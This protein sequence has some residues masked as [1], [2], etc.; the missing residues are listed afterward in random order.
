MFASFID[1]KIISLIEKKPPE[2]NV[3]IFDEKIQ[4]FKKNEL[5]VNIYDVNAE[6]MLLKASLD[7]KTIEN[8]VSKFMSQ[9]PKKAPTVRKIQLKESVDTVDTFQRKV[10][11]TFLFENIDT[12]QLKA[13]EEFI[14]KIYKEMKVQK[15]LQTKKREQFE[16]NPQLKV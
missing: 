2:P 8:Q 5:N 6:S 14:K 3:K 1:L 4:N 11:S 16:N 10:R 13:D 9:T 7:I 15:E 12:K